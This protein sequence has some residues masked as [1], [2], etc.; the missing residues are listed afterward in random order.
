MNKDEMIRLI[1]QSVNANL[2]GGQ[3]R[4]TLEGA[5]EVYDDLIQGIRASLQEGQEIKIPSVGKFYVNHYNARTIPHPKPQEAG[6]M[7]EV[8]AGRQVRFSAYPSLKDYINGR[9]DG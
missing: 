6:Q 7:L 4:M 9:E 2:V 5:R 1:Y 3:A 8:P